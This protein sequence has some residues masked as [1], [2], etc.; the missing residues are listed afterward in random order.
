MSKYNISA[1]RTKPG[2]AVI[3]PR[4]VKYKESTFLTGEKTLYALRITENV[5]PDEK[6]YFAGGDFIAVNHS[7]K[8]EGE[9]QIGKTP[10]ETANNLVIAINSSDNP[11]LEIY[12]IYADNTDVIVQKI[13]LDESPELQLCGSDNINLYCK[14]KPSYTYAIIVLGN[15][16]DEN[17]IGT[18]P[19]IFSCK[20]HAIS[21]GGNE[22]ARE[23]ANLFGCSNTSYMGCYGDATAVYNA[24]IAGQQYSGCLYVTSGGNL[25]GESLRMTCE[26]AG[27]YFN[28]K[29]STS[30]FCTVG[31]NLFNIETL[32]NSEKLAEVFTN[33]FANS[34]F[35][36]TRILDIN[37]IGD[38]KNE[39]GDI[40]FSSKGLKVRM[41]STN[42][43]DKNF[44]NFRIKEKDGNIKLKIK[45]QNTA[46]NTTQKFIKEINKEESLECLNPARR[47]ELKEKVNNGKK[48]EVEGDITHEVN[49]DIQ[50]EVEGDII[51]I[52]LGEKGLVSLADNANHQPIED[53]FNEIFDFNY[54]HT[55][56]CTKGASRKSSSLGVSGDLQDHTDSYH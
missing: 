48:E 17:L 5:K 18:I 37:K 31:Y 51:E 56:C 39:Q 52:Y 35:E 1:I 43:A 40:I 29:I 32:K 13:A 10:A 27:R 8:K 12:S 9:F 23:L 30:I 53:A 55:G 50:D 2:S 33:I 4:I 26:H 25:D 36:Q 15:I 45:L 11:A 14:Q 24:D 22:V 3:N 38:I 19:A 41:T 46:D 54:G 21:E 28:L 7:P 34:I 49:N 16:R 44:V 6:I 47:L 20:K 42:F